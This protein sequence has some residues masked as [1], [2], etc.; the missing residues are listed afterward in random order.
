[1]RTAL[2][3][4]VLEH[5]GGTQYDKL[6]AGDQVVGL[7]NAIDTGFRDK[8]LMGIG[9]MPCEFPGRQLRLFQGYI[10]N[11]FSHRIGYLVPV[12]T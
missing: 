7:E 5:I 2:A 4:R 6:W 3:G 9:E 1:M 10:H 12:L 11:Q 8:V